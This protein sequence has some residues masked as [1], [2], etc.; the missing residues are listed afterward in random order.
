ME[1]SV[2]VLRT[3]GIGTG[4]KVNPVAPV[5]SVFFFDA[6]LTLRKKKEVRS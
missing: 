3:K 4:A 6:L 5:H 1:F 2:F